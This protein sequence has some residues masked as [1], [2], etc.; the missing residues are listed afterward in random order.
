M[1]GS[2]I[3]GFDVTHGELPIGD[4]AAVDDADDVDPAVVLST[5]WEGVADDDGSMFDVLS[6]VELFGVEYNDGRMYCV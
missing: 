4:A 1:E 5:T 3:G 6:M 2:I